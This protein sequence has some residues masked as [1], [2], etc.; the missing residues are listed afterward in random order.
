DITGNMGHRVRAAVPRRPRANGWLPMPGW[1]GEYEWQGMVPWEE[2]PS[3][4]NPTAGRIIT[5]NNRVVA[6]SDS[7]Y[8]CT[9]CHPP[10][11]A[12]RIA[13]RLDSLDGLSV[14]SMEPIYMDLLS[15]PALAIRD[16]L[17]RH[18]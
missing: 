8:L 18:H 17:R 14:S 4:I 9:D 13:A 7:T 1:S 2:L 10:H 12:R 15:L 5:A 16:R 6:D 3:A 11:R